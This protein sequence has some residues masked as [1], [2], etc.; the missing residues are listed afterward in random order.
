VRFPWPTGWHYTLAELSFYARAAWYLAQNGRFDVIQ[1]VYASTCGS[2]AALVGALARRPSVVRLAGRGPQ[3]DM[4]H[5]LSH[6]LRSVLM[7]LLGRASAVACPSLDMAA[8][9]RAATNGRARVR[10]MPNGVDTARFSPGERSRPNA[11]SVMRLSPG[12]ATARLLDAWEIVAKELPQ[13]SL[14]IVGEGQELEP[15]RARAVPGVLLPGRQDDV[16]LRLRAASVFVLPTDAEGMSNALL[17]AMASG[18]ACVA[19]DIPAN[20]DAL[21]ETGVLVAPTPEAIARALLELLRSPEKARAQ[22]ERARARVLEHF[23]ASAMT[24]RYLCLYAELLE[25]RHT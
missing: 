11:I 21:G 13:A 1:G 8:E 12:K 19:T 10:H 25:R 2:L 22:G 6:P 24:A 14:E 17:E 7:G 15:S 3:G 4:A 18:L 9:L 23:A 16:P 20:R 5:L